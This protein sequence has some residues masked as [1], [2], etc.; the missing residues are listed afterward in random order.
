MYLSDIFIKH[1]QTQ[2][3]SECDRGNKCRKEGSSVCK[4]KKENF[5]NLRWAF[6]DTLRLKENIP[7]WISREQKRKVKNEHALF[8]VGE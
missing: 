5:M 3:A 2:N 7:S 6:N 1:I 4:V 8:G